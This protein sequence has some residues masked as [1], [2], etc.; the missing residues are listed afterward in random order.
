M[1]Q[2]RGPSKKCTYEG[3][4]YSSNRPSTLKRHR[5]SHCTEPGCAYLVQSEH[6]LNH[7]AA[8]H[9]YI[10][11]AHTGKNYSFIPVPYG[12]NGGVGNEGWPKPNAWPRK[13]TPEEKNANTKFMNALKADG[14][15]FGTAVSPTG[16][17][18]RRGSFFEPTNG[19]SRRTRRKTR[20]TRRC[21]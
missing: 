2:R 5:E 4:S 18:T 14:R 13:R 7:Y 17:R 1:S 19:G 9:P 20:R 15:N 3:C 16:A 12:K 11:R 21:N 6:R 8:E 10:F